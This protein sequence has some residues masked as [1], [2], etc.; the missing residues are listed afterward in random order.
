MSKFFT[1][2]IEKS[3]YVEVEAK[4]SDEAVDKALEEWEKN[5]PI[6][7]IFLEGEYEDEEDE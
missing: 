4:N 2:R 7:E 3:L 1:I 6:E 5:P